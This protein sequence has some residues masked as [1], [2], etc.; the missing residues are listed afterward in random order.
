MM[1]FR[2]AKT[3]KILSLTWF[4]HLG[5]DPRPIE[6]RRGLRF[7]RADIFFWQVKRL[8]AS[9]KQRWKY[10][11]VGL[12]LGWVVTSELWFILITGSRCP[13]LRHSLWKIR[14][15]TWWI[16]R[17]YNNFDEQQTLIWTRF[18]SCHRLYPFPLPY[19]MLSDGILNTWS[20]NLLAQ[21]PLEAGCIR[22]QPSRIR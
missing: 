8:V 13:A 12:G 16:I 10:T 20:T 9:S 7:L 17:I 4:P 2:N 14:L 21:F 3:V 5:W 6:T 22:D 15:Q 19:H 11:M 1:E 18:N